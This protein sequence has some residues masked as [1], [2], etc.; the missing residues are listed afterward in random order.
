MAV[1]HSHDDAVAL[2]GRVFGKILDREADKGGYEYVL[3]CLESGRKSVRDIVFEFISS[4]EFIDRFVM[5]KSPEK[6]VD[7]IYRLLLGRVP[8][9]EESL[10]HARHRFVR[11]GLR[12]FVD[13]V[14]SSPEYL[15]DV[16]Q[17]EI[18]EWGHA[19]DGIP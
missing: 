3:Y 18:P 11:M 13:R 14:M 15:E 4:E 1:Q 17:D 12:K 19:W 8:E 5:G 6:S 10:K 16:G 9:D 2:A 7:L